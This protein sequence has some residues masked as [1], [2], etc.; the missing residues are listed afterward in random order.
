[1]TKYLLSSTLF[2]RMID[3]DREYVCVSQDADD[4]LASEST[5]IEEQVL[6]DVVRNL[7]EKTDFVVYRET[8]SN[9]IGKKIDRTVENDTD[10]DD[11]TPTSHETVMDPTRKS[12][13]KS[14]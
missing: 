10:V 9:H 1:M 4:Y 2:S 8:A 6:E 13:T 3:S 14:R 11:T 5:V 7:D 12:I